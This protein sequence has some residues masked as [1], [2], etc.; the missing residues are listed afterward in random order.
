MPLDALLAP[1]AAAVAVARVRLWRR[2]REHPAYQPLPHFAV[3]DWDWDLWLVKGGR[4]SGK[5]RV[6]VEYVMP[7]LRSIG[8]KARVGIGAP[9]IADARDVCAE[10]E[11]GLIT[12]YRDEFT[13][14]NRSMGEAR[15][16]GGA[17]VKFLGSE[18][19]N[20][21][22]GPQWT[23]LWADELALWN[24]DSW[25]QAQFG[26]RLGDWPRAVATT[27]PKSRKFLREL[28]KLPST[29]VS[30]GTMHQNPYLSPRVAARL[31]RRYAG[32]R[33][34]R[35]ELLGQDIEEI[36]GALWTRAMIDDYRL[37]ALPERLGLQRVVVAVDPAVTHGED[38]DETGICVAGIG[39]DGDYYILHL[40]GY[41]LAPLGWARRAVDLY[42]Q[43]QADRLLGER[44][45]GGEMVEAT[46]RTIRQD[47]SLKTIHASRGKTVR[48]EPVAALY[49]Q[50]RV[51]HVGVFDAAEEQM[52]AFPVAA[53]LDDDVDALVYAVTELSE[54]AGGLGGEL[55]EPERFTYSR[56]AY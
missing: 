48:A 16:R 4:G 17:Y 29:A 12:L 11:S 25:D 5:T 19:P 14:Y 53:E 15:H 31:M 10:G 24:V 43:Y 51:H 39:D 37:P 1:E 54:G 44:N 28:E 22:N 2:Y 18:E 9:T 33:L 6:G 52:C 3:P 32:T 47:V 27:T 21:W 38:S 46:I 56:S 36:E 35:Q 42:D 7:H 55:Y 26:L 30:Y 45:N 20:R 13:L 40:Q 23:L 50:G 34:E 41:R 8:A 49:E